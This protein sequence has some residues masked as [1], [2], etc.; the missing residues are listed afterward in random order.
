MKQVSLELPRGCWEGLLEEK[1]EEEEE[2]ASGRVLTSERNCP[3]R[4]NCQG[5]IRKKQNHHEQEL[6]VYYRY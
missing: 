2:E 6:R 5:P 4:R 1:G 3:T